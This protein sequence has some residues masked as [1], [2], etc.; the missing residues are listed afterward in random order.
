MAQTPPAAALPD[1]VVERRV[2]SILSQMTLEEKVDLIA[3]VD[4]FYLRGLARLS[5]PRLRM[6]DGPMGVR[7]DGPATAFGG[8]IALAATWNPALAERIGVE[9][10]RDARARGVHFLLAP[11]VNI[12]RA[13]MAARNFEYFGEDPFLASRLAVGFING[14][15][16]QEVS[17][18]VKHFAANNSEFDRNN[19]DSLVDDRTLREIYLPAFEAAVKEAKVGAIMDGYNLTNGSYMSQH[20]YLNDEVAK[21]E[22]SFRG[23]IMSDWISTYDAIGAANGGLDIEMPSGSQFNREKLLPAIK[24]GKVSVSTIDDKVRRQLR[25]AIRFG[26]F[27]REQLDLSILRHNPQGQQAALQGARE[28]MVLLKNE[29]ALLPLDGERVKS[30]LVVGPN[31][32]PAVIGG[33]GSSLV[34]PFNSVSIRDGLVAAAGS[35]TDVFYARGLPPLSEIISATQ[36]SSNG[37]GGEPGLRAEYFAA[38]DL[39]GTPV[40]ARLESR[41]EIGLSNGTP[42]FPQGTLSERWTGY[43]AVPEDGTYDV[44][45]GAAGDLGGLYRLF[46]DDKLV[47]DNWNLNKAMVDYVTLALD[48]GN[49]KVV[50]EH[51][52]RQKW[53]GE[54][55]QL[56]FS[57][58]GDRVEAT[59]KALAAKAD[60]VVI[61]AGFDASSESE[62]SD[63]TFR[64]PPG[65]DELI[66]A[67]AA[68]NKQTVVV[69]TAG[70]A[71]DMNGWIERVPALLQAWYPGQ[72][73]GT[74]VAEILFGAVNP[75]GRLPATFE[76]HWQDNPAHDYYYPERGTQRIVYREGIFVGYRGYEKNGVAPLFPFGHGLSYTTFEYGNLKISPEKTG[77]GNV[78]VTFDLTNTGSRAGAD[79]AQVYVADKHSSVPRPPKELKGFAKVHLEPGETQRVTVEL[80]R[81]SFSY[82]DVEARAWRAEPGVFDVLVGRSSEAIELRG[83]LAFTQK[84]IH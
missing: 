20:A 4:F 8:G 79:V 17:A 66:Q 72:E 55:L 37:S 28:G 12:Y 69:M 18:T 34:E 58:H 50:L 10:G 52:G 9:F 80:N 49:H 21:N 47:I 56:G 68:A 71:V 74:A 19:T 75:S 35:N 64:L 41:I 31:A 27:D 23:V 38:A 62:G 39:S 1:T 5:V 30:I 29:N 76:R 11:G 65:Q 6:A 2:D 84:D 61:A 32:H 81:R 3:G 53:P 16:S 22:W 70:G 43:Y 63:R 13:P 24:A 83:N 44:F 60:V 57:R 78:L 40:L 48:A 67:M 14:V 15:Q 59:A 25:V 26:W 42:R 46:L 73:G 54:R 77:D 82:Y 51:H 33:G 45:V 7:N 36:F